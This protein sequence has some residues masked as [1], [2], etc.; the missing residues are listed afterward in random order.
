M[1][2]EKNYSDKGV[3]PLNEFFWETY[4]IALPVLLGYIVFLLKKQKKDRDANSQ[5]TMLLLRVQLIDYHEKWTQR[6]YISKHGLE[7]FI[8]MY[9]AYHALGGNGMVTH[10]LEEVK[11]LPIK[12]SEKGA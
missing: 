6:G 4:K 12:T 11:D 10:L 7:N 2:S 3:M 1:P 8:E 9:N 5:G